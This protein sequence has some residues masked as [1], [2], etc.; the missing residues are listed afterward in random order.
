MLLL[1]LLLF[2]GVGQ[3]GGDLFIANSIDTQN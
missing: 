2:F 3:F 1:L